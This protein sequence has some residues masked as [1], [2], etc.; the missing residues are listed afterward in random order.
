MKRVDVACT[1]IFDSTKQNIVMVH[2]QKGGSSYWSLPGGAVEAG[3]TLEQDA[4]RETKEESG[5]DVEIG[6]I[7]SVQ[8]IFF[9]DAVIT[10]SSLRS[11]L[12]LSAG[13]L[14]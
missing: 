9:A 12:P 6:G 11:M 14:K 10:P 7:H 2:N 5:L 13:N 3:E 8:E 4:I 1:L